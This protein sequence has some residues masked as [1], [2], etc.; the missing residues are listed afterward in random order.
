MRLVD[1]AHFFCRPIDEGCFAVDEPAF[2]RAEVAAV[3]GDGAMIAHD[4]IF[5]IGDDN[6]IE[7]TAINEAMRNVGFGDGLTI[8]D[9]LSMIDLQLV[10]G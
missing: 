2:D 1:D 4:E 10:A 5:V 8:H 3:A 6:F 7:R 9:H